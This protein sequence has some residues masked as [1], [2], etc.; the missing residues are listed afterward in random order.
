L[1]AFLY[2]YLRHSG[3]DPESRR[4]FLLC[5]S[6][7][8]LSFL[9]RRESVYSAWIPPLEPQAGMT[10]QGD[11]SVPQDDIRISFE[12]LNSKLVN[13]KFALVLLYQRLQLINLLLD[14]VYLRFD[15]GSITCRRCGSG[16]NGGA[17][18]YDPLCHKRIELF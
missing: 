1:A 11:P 3:L 2:V 14:L 8:F 15:C 10:E 12:V 7:N 6:C 4:P 13:F 5:H 18:R 17:S 16:N 9:R